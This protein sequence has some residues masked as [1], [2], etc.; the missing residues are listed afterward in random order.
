[1][2]AILIIIGLILFSTNVDAQSIHFTNLQSNPTLLNPALTAYTNS[3]MRLGLNTRQQWVSFPKYYRTY[4]MFTDMKIPG[5]DV[6]PNW[7]KNEN[8]IGLGFNLYGDVAGDGVMR[9]NEGMLTLAYHTPKGFFDLSTALGI[10]FYQK[11]VNFDNLYFNNQWNGYRFDTE[12]TNSENS[13]GVNRTMALPNISGGAM[14]NFPSNRLKKNYRVQAGLSYWHLFAKNESFYD[15]SNIPDRKMAYHLGYKG[16]LIKLSKSRKIW[17][18][19]SFLAI[20]QGINEEY[21][22]GLNTWM[23][24]TPDFLY[25]IW[26]RHQRE[27][28][29]SLGYQPSQGG[30]FL[31]EDNLQLD[32]IFFS[33][34]YNYLLNN[35]SIEITFILKSNYQ[36]CRCM[37]ESNNPIQSGRGYTAKR[38]KLRNT[39]PGECNDWQM[40]KRKGVPDFYFDVNV[41][42]FAGDINAPGASI[43]NLYTIAPAGFHFTVG[44][45]SSI[46]YFGL[47]TG[48]E[49]W[50]DFLLIP[51]QADVKYTIPGQ[52][53]Q[54]AKST[55]YFVYADLGYSLR[56]MQQVPEIKAQKGGL[57]GSLGVGVD[58]PLRIL[59]NKALVLS[60]GY[61]HQE[62]YTEYTNQPQ[63]VDPVSRLNYLQLKFGVRF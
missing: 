31:K 25:G 37:D 4:S 34:D 1:M 39:S 13:Q 22:Y 54:G 43:N 17:I 42:Y 27:V 33:Y 9:T 12:L 15:F 11:S 61:H 62:L 8:W 2:K 18:D 38:E 56:T 32:K 35:S 50:N 5:N 36:N 26:L 48:L 55:L 30:T 49:Y 58:K 3:C 21:F 63:G 46:Y 20:K 60:I 29:F 59:N 57:A 7:I 28:T 19:A 40:D 6:K 24:N 23:E 45:G 41:N 14:I 10:G 52:G 53:K 47:L 44:K 51:L 16:P